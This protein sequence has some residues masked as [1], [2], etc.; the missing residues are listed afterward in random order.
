[1]NPM[2]QNYPSQS[3][4]TYS[5]MPIYQQN[6]MD[7]NTMDAVTIDSAALIRTATQSNALTQKT[8]EHVFF[9]YT[10][11]DDN[12]YFVTFKTILQDSVSIL[13]N[14][15]YDHEFF[16]NNSAADY[17]VTC[18]YI[19][20]SLIISLLNNKEYRMDHDINILNRRVL[21]SMNQKFNLEQ[22]LKQVLPSHLMKH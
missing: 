1:M 13:D 16:Y 6:T 15:D 8:N 14:H 7:M 22:G 21:L 19:P 4:H 20:H 5:E 9:Y 12:F 10:P 17:H 3:I 18:K 2:N 11:T